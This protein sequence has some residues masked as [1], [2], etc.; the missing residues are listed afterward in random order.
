MTDNTEHIKQNM[1][2]SIFFQLITKLQ[3]IT[4]YSH[5]SF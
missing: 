3:T 2:S 1:V 4:K 5:D